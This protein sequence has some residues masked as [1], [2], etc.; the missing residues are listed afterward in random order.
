MVEHMLLSVKVI[1]L[2]NTSKRKS[3]DNFWGAVLFGTYFPYSMV[4]INLWIIYDFVSFFPER[5]YFNLKPIYQPRG[6]HYK[7][8][9]I[10]LLFYPHP[11]PEV[12]RLNRNQVDLSSFV[13][14][15]FQIDL[16]RH[17]TYLS[18]FWFIGALFWLSTI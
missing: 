8:N 15:N 17:I 5:K 1:K 4:P 11:S 12:K 3:L 10:I 2:W 13:L 14:V 6:R 16:A 18:W 7:I 9:W